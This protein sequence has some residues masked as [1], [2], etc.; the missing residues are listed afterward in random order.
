MRGKS[1]VCRA[2]AVTSLVWMMLV[3][4]ILFY[5]LDSG[6][7]SFRTSQ[8]EYIRYAGLDFCLISFPKILVLMTTQKDHIQDKCDLCCQVVIKELLR[9]NLYIQ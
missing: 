6:S 2:V 4:F 1:A 3:V 7:S 8:G 5:F 9:Q